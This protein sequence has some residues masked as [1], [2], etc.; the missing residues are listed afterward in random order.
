[1]PDAAVPVGAELASGV[2]LV[3]ARFGPYRPT[4]T[5]VTY[6]PDLVPNRALVAVARA[7]V[8]GR[9]GVLLVTEGL[10]PNRQYG[11]HVHVR[12]CGPAPADAGPHYQNRRDPQQPS[13]DPQYANPENEVWLD[14]TTDARGRGL[15]ATTVDWV[16]RDHRPRSVVL[17]ETHTQ[18]EPGSAGMAG[19]RLACVTVWF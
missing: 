12:P 9:T 18:T 10:V 4:A 2:G 7:S 11:A 15:T 5:A 13:T 16:F 17:H 19:A 1:M 3:L 8:A 14:F 6:R